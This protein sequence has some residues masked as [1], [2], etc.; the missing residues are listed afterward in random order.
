MMMGGSM[1]KLVVRLLVAGRGS[2][3]AGLIWAGHSIYRY[4]MEIGGNFPLFP[5]F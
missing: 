4:E 1:N 5:T 2:L 3:V